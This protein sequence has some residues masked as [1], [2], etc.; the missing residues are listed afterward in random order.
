MTQVLVTVV[1]SLYQLLFFALFLEEN[2]NL[3]HF[4]LLEQRIISIYI[5]CQLAAGRLWIMMS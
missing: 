5:V 2:K 3:I 4:Y 1:E